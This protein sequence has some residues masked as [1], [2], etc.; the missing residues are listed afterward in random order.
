MARKR[1]NRICSQPNCGR[2]ATARNLCGV[3]Y[4]IRRNRKQV[5]TESSG[6][7]A[8]PEVVL[9]VR[10]RRWE[11]LGNLSE[12]LRVFNAREE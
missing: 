4:V 6:L 3:H 12:S 2:Q 8:D 5:G 10:K 9:P 11:W 1:V 7:H